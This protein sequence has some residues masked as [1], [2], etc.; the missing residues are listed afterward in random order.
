[1]P[2]HK[3]GNAEASIYQMQDGRWRAA[4]TIGRKP[5]GSP[6]RKVYT[7]ATRHEVKDQLTDALKD[8]KSGIPIV[9]EKQT[10]AKFF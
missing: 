8:L 1:M 6:I 5:D 4:V 10:V 7:A 9:S 2:R 3:R